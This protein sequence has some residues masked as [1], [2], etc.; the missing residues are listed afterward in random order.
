MRRIARPLRSDLYA[1]VNVPAE[2]GTAA[3][4]RT[5]RLVARLADGAGLASRLR[6]VNVS[7]RRDAGHL[8][9]VAQ[10]D[11]LQRCHEATA[12]LHYE[13]VVRMRTDAYYGFVAPPPHRLPPFDPSEHVAYVGFLGGGE[14]GQRWTDDRF[15]ML[16]GQRAQ[17][18]FLRAFPE[19]LRALNS[20]AHRA[21]GTSPSRTAPECIA[22]GALSDGR[23]RT[24]DIRTRA[25]CSSSSGGGGGGGGCG[26]C[27]SGCSQANSLLV[28][29]DCRR[30]IA[31]APWVCG[32]SQP[33]PVLVL[34]ESCARLGTPCE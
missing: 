23:V 12:P 11:G 3:I 15:A 17:D 10:A 19:R 31:A 6:V 7:T 2:W 9:G 21:I 20:G 1:F 34:C 8:P 14:C 13:W 33:P 27:G 32:P 26:G 5:R 30:E 16:H 24:V 4:T 25:E 18:Q 29:T 22:G 28:R